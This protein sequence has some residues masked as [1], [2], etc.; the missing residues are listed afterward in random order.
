MTDYTHFNR[1]NG[2]AASD[3]LTGGVGFDLFYGGA[4]DDMFNGVGGQNAAVYNGPSSNY[5]ISHADNAPVQISGPEGTDTL[6]SVQFAIFTDKVVPLYTAASLFAFDE[7]VYLRNNTDVATAVQNGIYANGRQHFD[8]YGKYESRTSEF[9]GGLDSTYYL[10]VNPEAG[11]AHLS[12]STHYQQ[13]GNDEGR[14]T[15]LL[16]DADYYLANNRDVAAAG[17][18]PWTHFS[19]YGWR[20]NRNP[21]PFFDVSDYLTHNP[22]VA[23]AGYN[24][25]FHYLNWGQAEGRQIYMDSSF[26]IV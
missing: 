26:P 7:D 24:P 13:Y 19:F 9:N 3:S 17:V 25:L 20:E 21:S 16:F 6:N 23:A 5:T 11:A 14:S 15:Q 22:D 8:L 12:A 1:I 2:T 10:Q 18:D 4:G